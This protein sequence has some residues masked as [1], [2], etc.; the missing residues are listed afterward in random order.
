MARL[1]RITGRELLAALQRGG[2]ELSHVRGSN[3]YLRRGA[4]R[5]VPVPVHAG[6][7]IPSGTLKAILRQAD[8]SV[9]DLVALL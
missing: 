6:E 9:E 3:H 1:P 5:I 2:F 4:G 7:T 8:M